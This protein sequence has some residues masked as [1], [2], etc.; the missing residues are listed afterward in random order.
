MPPI[1]EA[2]RRGAL[3]GHAVEVGWAEV[4]QGREMT[5]LRRLQPA[6]GVG[7]HRHQRAD[8]HRAA[9][10]A[11]AGNVMRLRR[12]PAGGE[13]LLTGFDQ[14]VIVGIDILHEQPGPHH[15]VGQRQTLAAE[16]LLIPAEDR[17][18]L[19][20][21]AA[22]LGAGQ[23]AGPVVSQV[24]PPQTHRLAAPPLVERTVRVGGVVGPER[25]LGRRRRGLADPRHRTGRLAGRIGERPG[26]QRRGL[27][28]QIAAEEAAEEAVFGDHA[29]IGQ[30]ELVRLFEPA[31]LG[32]DTGIFGRPQRGVQL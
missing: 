17:T 3:K 7:V 21:R 13:Q 5:H 4:V 30:S 18:C 16:Q 31:E 11:G 28:R 9:L 12:Q 26:P 27:V 14:A 2:D 20:I 1:A 32:V 22:R 10:D 19:L 25:D 8:I 15:M 29:G 23:I 6:D 24:A